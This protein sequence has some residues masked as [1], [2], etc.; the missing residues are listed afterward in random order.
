M[1]E[2][3]ENP[4][5]GGEEPQPGQVPPGYGAPGYAPPGYVYPPGYSPPPG[6]VPP[7]YQPVAVVPPVK[8]NGLAIASLV[9]G[10]LWIWWIGS[11]L[12]LAFGYSAKAQIDLSG[13]T[14]GG[15]GLAI[16]GIVLGW[17]GAGFFLLFVLLLGS[18]P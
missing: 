5:R 8:T 15:R 12:A 13:G 17:V 9:L 18:M 16:A 4:G 11:A 6:Q 14:Q 3:P 7:L 1:T 10:I 2:T